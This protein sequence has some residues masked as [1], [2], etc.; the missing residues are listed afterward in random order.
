MEKDLELRVSYGHKN[1]MC[2]RLKSDKVC[3]ALIDWQIYGK[4][5]DCDKKMKC[6]KV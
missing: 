1:E 6:A 3:K 4:I 2:K 5:T